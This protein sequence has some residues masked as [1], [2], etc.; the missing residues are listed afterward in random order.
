M[1]HDVLVMESYEKTYLNVGILFS[2]VS[3]TVT[4]PF[5]GAWFDSSSCLIADKL[6]LKS[7]EI[8]VLPRTP[9]RSEIDVN[10]LISG[11]KSRRKVLWQ[12]SYPAIEVP[13]FDTVPAQF[14]W[15]SVQQYSLQSQIFRR[16]ASSPSSCTCRTLP[17]AASPRHKAQSS[18]TGPW[19]ATFEWWRARRSRSS[20][21]ESVIGRKS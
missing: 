2:K 3:N 19:G 8:S 20:G 5:N 4:S 1:S 10:R 21:E 11:L 12:L 9:F 7:L 18:A 14:P 6:M 15:V 13:D 16:R 17:E